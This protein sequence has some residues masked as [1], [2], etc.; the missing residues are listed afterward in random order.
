MSFKFLCERCQHQL[1]VPEEIQGK[2]A[3]CPHCGEIQTVPQDSGFNETPMGV[4]S[5][6]SLPSELTPTRIRFDQV[7]QNAWNLFSAR[8]VDFLLLGLIFG[9]ILLLFFV[10]VF[11]MVL[12]GGDNFL[13]SIL[14]Q[15][16]GGILGVYLQLGGIRYALHLARRHESRLSLLFP[17]LNLYL[18]CL[19]ASFLLW[20]ASWGIMIVSTI[21][22][23]VACGALGLGV[24]P[25]QAIFWTSIL[26]LLFA[27]PFLIFLTV[28][29]MWCVAFIADRNE[30]PIE[31]L[32]SSWQFSSGNVLAIFGLLFVCGLLCLLVTFCTCGLGF[33]VAIPFANC[34]TAVA[35]LMMTGQPLGTQQ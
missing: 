25:L 20:L 26:G 14:V 6:F 13:I 23:G 35:Y 10:L 11:P 31:A 30:G 2:K 4:S 7:F 8:F 9:G 27:S 22:G 5:P 32:G 21:A 17:D 12:M 19:G 3:Q 28:R 16:T 1:Q 18:K 24:N 29:L 15:I 34:Y 33:I